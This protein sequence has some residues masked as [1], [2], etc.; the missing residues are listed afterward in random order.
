MNWVKIC[1]TTSLEDALAAVEAGADALGFVFAPSPRRIS[2]R[3]AAAITGALPPSVEKIGVFV[4]QSLGLVLDTVERAGLTGVQL[5]G[6][7]DVRYARQLQQKNGRL[8]IMKAIS[9]R[10]VGDGKGKGLALAMQD[11]A[12]KTFGALLLDS[13]SGSR[14]GGTG[15]TFD[16]QEAAP[17][18][19]LLGRKFPL[20]IAGGLNAENVGKALRIFQPWGVD[21]VS[22]VEQAPGKKEPAKLRAFI[23]AVRAAEAT[24]AAPD[25]ENAVTEK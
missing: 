20:I 12:D 5:H 21:V 25:A 22:G 18:A 3:D 24:V 10:E 6:E 19:R 1:G 16:W 9:L 14:R 23:A 4:N 17:M 11:E 15:T 2:P 13:G 7:E 8:R